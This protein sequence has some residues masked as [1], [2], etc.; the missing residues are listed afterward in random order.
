MK[1]DEDDEFLSRGSEGLSEKEG[2][3][4]P[5]N[6]YGNPSFDIHSSF[7][8]TI[9]SLSIVVVVVVVVVVSGAA[10]GRNLT[11]LVGSSLL[12]SAGTN[13]GKCVLIVC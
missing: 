2:S 6:K 5:G 1:G 13:M 9:S 3:K 8:S 7:L 11:I 4:L 10:G 12:A